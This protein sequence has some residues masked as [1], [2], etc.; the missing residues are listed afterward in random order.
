MSSTSS[1]HRLFVRTLT[2]AKTDARTLSHAE[3]RAKQRLEKLARNAR[4]ALLQVVTSKICGRDCF[5]VQGHYTFH[6][7]RNDNLIFR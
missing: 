6:R 7:R 5:S 3:A 2:D 4:E 1:S